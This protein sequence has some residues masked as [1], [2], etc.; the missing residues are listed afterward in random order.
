MMSVV[1]HTP[2]VLSAL[3]ALLSV[4]HAHH[5]SGAID[6]YGYFVPARFEAIWSSYDRQGRGRLSLLDVLRL[7]WD[8][9]HLSDPF[10][11]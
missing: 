4:L 3:S 11:T 7:V 6:Q 1:S 9:A 2:R 8:K 10:G 5:S